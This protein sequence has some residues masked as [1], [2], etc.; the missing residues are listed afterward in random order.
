MRLQGQKELE[1]HNLRELRR[2]R[3][4]EQLLAQ[5]AREKRAA[6]LTK[7]ARLCGR[8][9]RHRQWVSFWTWP[10]GA[11]GR[12]GGA[13]AVRHPRG[14]AW[15][16]GPG[17]LPGGGRRARAAGAD[18]G[19]ARQ[20]ARAAPAAPPRTIQVGA[21]LDSSRSKYPRRPSFSA[22]SDS[23][24]QGQGCCQTGGI[25]AFRTD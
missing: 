12:D 3:E 9:F 17:S 2:L 25:R 4:Q 7:A 10:A 22:A 23:R 19:G 13:A 5:E 20:G 21:G 18:A 11:A 24:P 14:G 1:A 6:D 8:I 16:P 15:G